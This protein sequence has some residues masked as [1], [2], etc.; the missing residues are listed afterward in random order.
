[1]IGDASP[2]TDALLL[3]LARAFALNSFYGGSLTKHEG[4]VIAAVAERFLIM[5]ADTTVSL[6][7][8]DQLKYVLAVLE[9]AWSNAAPLAEQIVQRVSA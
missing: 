4:E 6:L 7:E 3:D 5:G 9:D 8:R 1:M 2:V